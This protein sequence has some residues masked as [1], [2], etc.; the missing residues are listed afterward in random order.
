MKV[1]GPGA[2]S[3]PQ[4]TRRTGKTGGKDGSFSRLLNS[5]DD[6]SAEPG[7][8]D[9]PLAMNSIDALLAAQSVGDATDREARRRMIRRSESILDKLEEIRHA[10]LLGTITESQL[11]SLALLVRSH[12]DTIDDPRLAGLLDEIEL[13]AEVELAKFSRPG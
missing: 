9:T 10:L 4:A 5:V 12:R 6:A 13:R 2:T 3:A 8:V 11:N 7:K 1:T